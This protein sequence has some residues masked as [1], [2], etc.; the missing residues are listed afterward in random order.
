MNNITRRFAAIVGMGLAFIMPINRAFSDD[1]FELFARL[2][3]EWWQWALSIPTSVNPQIDTTG[4]NAVVGQRGPIWFL[5]GIFDPAN[6]GNTA[7]RTCSVPQGTALF[8]PIINGVGINTPNVCNQPLESVSQVRADAAA[9]VDGAVN[10]SVTLDGVA[11]RIP[12]RVQSKV[13]A[14]AFPADNVFN[15][16]FI[17]GPG[18]CQ[19]AYIPLQQVTDSMSCSAR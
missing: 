9:Q 10:L 16:P 11:I 13:F 15:S 3:A 4:A 5:A 17:C 6:N 12:P 19:P 1:N 14:V 18:G 8:F 2:S 7:T